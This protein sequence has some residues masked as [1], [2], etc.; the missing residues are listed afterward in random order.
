M[1]DV[2]WIIVGVAVLLSAM[3]VF[4]KYAPNTVRRWRQQSAI[5]LM[6]DGNRGWRRSL[7]LKIA[8]DPAAAS[9]SCDGCDGCD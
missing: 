4:R 8:P 9:K 5:A 7:G 6:R 3:F 1:I 2:Q